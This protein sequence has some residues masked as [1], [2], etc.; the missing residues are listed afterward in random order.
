MSLLGSSVGTQMRTSAI[1]SGWMDGFVETRLRI[2]QGSTLDTLSAFLPQSIK[3]I[4]NQ[5]DFFS[6][7]ILLLYKERG[8]EADHAR[9]FK[10][11]I[12]RRTGKAVMSRNDT[13][14]NSITPENITELVE[15]MMAVRK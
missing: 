12:L 8:E 6:F 7:H 10:I 1:E 9:R 3:Y 14:K 4:F 13:Y 2:S 15:E 5:H 11:S